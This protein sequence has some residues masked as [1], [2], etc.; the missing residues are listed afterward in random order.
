VETELFHVAGEKGRER[1]RERE[2]ER[3]RQTMLIVAFRDFV[4]APKKKERLEP[5]LHQ[6]T[7]AHTE[8]QYHH[9]HLDYTEGIHYAAASL[10]S[11]SFFLKVKIC[12]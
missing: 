3:D 4:K 1:E 7:S 9:L 5:Y 6:N 10:V 2:R 12:S 8:V 11:Y